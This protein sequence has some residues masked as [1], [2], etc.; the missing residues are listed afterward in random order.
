MSLRPHHEDEAVTLYHGDCV[1]V[2]RQLPDCSVDAVVT[3]PPYEIGFMGK[4]WDGQGIAYSVEMWTEALRVLKPG[5]HLISFGGCRTWHRMAVAIEDAGFQIRENIAWLFAS[6]F[7]KSLDVSKAIDKAAG[8]ERER[9][10]FSGGIA[11]GGGN[12]GGGNSVRVNDGDRDSDIPATSAAQQW[13]GWG[14][15]LKPAFEPIVVARKPLIGTVAANVLAHGTGALNID[16]C[17]ID[18]GGEVVS[19]PQS[20]PHKRGQGAGEY[21]ISTRDTDR[22]REAQRASVERTNTLG[23]WP[24]NVILDESQA[25]ALDRMSGERPGGAYPAQRGGGVDT[26]F[27]AGPPTEGGARQMGDS[28]GASRF[29]KVVKEDSWNNDHANTAG[30]TSPPPSASGD[31][32]PDVVATSELRGTSRRSRGR[33][34]SATPTASSPSDATATAMTTSTAPESWRG[35][36]RGRRTLSRSRASGVGTSELTDTT[37]TTP[38]RSTSDGSAGPATSNGTSSSPVHGGLDSL[39]A[40]FIY[41]PKAD[42]AQRP[43]VNGVAHPTVK[44]LDLMRY[45][46]RL[47]TPPGGVVLEPFA[48][49]G[50]TLEACVIEGFRCI[51]IERESDYLPLILA[52]LTKPIE[53]VMF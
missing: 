28:G 41:Q 24:A 37:T 21:A 36:L 2:M 29:F 43:R 31:S 4:G 10:P 18:T 51:G 45:L 52:R 25:A 19:T 13:Q 22:M 44:N 9:V 33:S 15:A 39:G 35:L 6:G 17:R 16:G 12:Y 27:G 14:T 5:G 42:T 47:V 53:P 46:V 23:R 1:E 38:S 20:D 32:A 11:P 50:T 48:G 34:T 49:S 30:T 8:V 7:P 26:G 40:R 3:D